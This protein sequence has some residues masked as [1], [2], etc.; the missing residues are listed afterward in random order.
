[1][2]A[3]NDAGPAVIGGG[4]ICLA[5]GPPPRVAPPGTQLAPHNLRHANREP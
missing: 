4:R 3:P 5:I 1:M 2:N